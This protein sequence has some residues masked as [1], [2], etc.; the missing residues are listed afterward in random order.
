MWKGRGLV[1]R[2]RWEAGKKSG[3]GTQQW[4]NSKGQMEFWNSHQRFQRTIYI[5]TVRSQSAASASESRFQPSEE[6]AVKKLGRIPVSGCLGLWD[7]WRGWPDTL[8]RGFGLLVWGH[9]V[10]NQQ[11]YSHWKCKGT[12]TSCWPQT[13]SWNSLLFSHFIIIFLLLEPFL[14]A[15]FTWSFLPTHQLVSQNSIL[16]GAFLLL[17][18]ILPGSLHLLPRT[19]TI[20]P[21][22]YSPHNLSSELQIPIS[23]CILIYIFIAP[24]TCLKPN[25]S[26]LPLIHSVFHYVLSWL[27]MSLPF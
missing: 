14:L 22:W 27:I 12:E 19:C 20:N 15:S 24:K 4:G 26:P 9:L 10:R 13:F 3:S 23:N 17:L 7:S 25:P 21:Q 18:Y 8:L 2:K 11:L 6:R 5:F 16:R 1:T